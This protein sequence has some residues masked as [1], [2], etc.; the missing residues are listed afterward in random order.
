LARVR[1]NPF[2]L[3]M[4]YHTKH[5]VIIPD[6]HQDIAWVKRILAQE[7]EADLF[8]F[9]GDYFDSHLAL[10]HRTSTAATCRF[11]IDLQKHLGERIV[12]LLGNHDIQYLEARRDCLRHHVPR[13]LSYRCGSAFKASAAAKIAKHL[14]TVFWSNARL[15]VEVNGWLLSHAG[16]HSSFWPKRPSVAESLISIQSECEHAL[17]DI[18]H[19]NDP[20]LQ[21][22]LVRG[23]E[24]RNGGITW[25]DWNDEF[26][27]DL[28][29]P[30][31]V[32]HTSN[33]NGARQLGRSWC[34]DGGQTCYGILTSAGL[35]TRVV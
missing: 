8:V 19:T 22:G 12:F 2:T 16:V 26:R 29:L 35:T 20:L 34:I 21:A 18:N 31:I 25:Q 17:R 11:L 3:E 33:P 13:H 4:I 28:P 27:D 15:F 6:V 30:Q 9:L 7:T 32:G 14:P 23:G 5:I 10:K 24:A 1:R